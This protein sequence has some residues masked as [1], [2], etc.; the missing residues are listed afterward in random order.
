[1]QGYNC[2]TQASTKMSP[3]N[4]LFARHP[5]VPPAHVHKF[6]EP[7]DLYDVKLWLRVC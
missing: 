1:M 5:V 7:I 3:Y 6:S 2:S 4:M